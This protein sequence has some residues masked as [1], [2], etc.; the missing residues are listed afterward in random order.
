MMASTNVGAIQATTYYEI[1]DTNLIKFPSQNSNPLDRYFLKS[2]PSMILLLL[3]T[4]PKL[5]VNPSTNVGVI[6]ATTYCD[7]NLTKS[8]S[9]NSYPLDRFFSKSIPSMLL[10]LLTT[11]HSFVYNPSTNMINV[12]RYPSWHNIIDTRMDRRVKNIIPTL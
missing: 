8:L 10:L 3:T 6:L 1:Y 4:S 5:C 9:H 12:F 2:I 11:F 7:T